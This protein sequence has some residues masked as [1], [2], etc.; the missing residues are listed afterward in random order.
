MKLGNIGIIIPPCEI[1]TTGVYHYLTRWGAS[2]LSGGASVSIG[3]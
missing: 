2:T 1:V 3:P